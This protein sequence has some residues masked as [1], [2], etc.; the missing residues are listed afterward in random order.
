MVVSGPDGQLNLGHSEA[1]QLVSRISSAARDVRIELVPVKSMFAYLV[2]SVA[3]IARSANALH[4][5]Q[6][7]LVCCHRRDRAEDLFD[8]LVGLARPEFAVPVLTP[9]ERGRPEA[10]VAERRVR[11]ADE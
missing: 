2:G 7:H 8:R 6:R 11:P 1:A 4:T 3:E 9:A 5:Y 10:R